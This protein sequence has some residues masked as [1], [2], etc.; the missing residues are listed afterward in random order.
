[1]TRP[2][3]CIELASLASLASQVFNCFFSLSTQAFLDDDADSPC[4]N[5][6][7]EEVP[8]CPP[9]TLPPHSCCLK[10]TELFYVVDVPARVHTNDTDMDLKWIFPKWILNHWNH[11]TSRCPNLVIIWTTT[12][13]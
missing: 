6:E 8:F 13:Y 7:D 2:V 1:M 9:A 4:D 11:Y 12:R 3:S 5:R 10:M